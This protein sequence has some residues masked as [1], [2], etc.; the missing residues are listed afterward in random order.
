MSEGNAG[1]RTC[2]EAA[3]ACSARRE[4]DRGPQWKPKALSLWCKRGGGEGGERAPDS[5]EGARP[6]GCGGFGNQS[7][8]LKEQGSL[9]PEEKLVIPEVAAGVATGGSWAP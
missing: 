3:I 7:L 1:V 5:Q 6:R 8:R 2:S 9:A 4:D